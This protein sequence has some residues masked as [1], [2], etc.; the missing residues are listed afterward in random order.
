MKVEVMLESRLNLFYKACGATR[1][2][3]SSYPDLKAML[4]AEHSPIRLILF[5]VYLEDIPT[6]VSTHFVRH[7]IGVEHFVES[8]RDNSKGRNA[9]RANRETPVNHLMVC[10]AQSLIYMARKRLCHKADEIT[11]EI[12][13][14]I[15]KGVCEIMPEF[16]TVLVPDCLYRGK[17]YEMVP[18]SVGR[19]EIE[20]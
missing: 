1:A 17:C 10:N 5:S 20:C 6:Y 9:G 16:Y 8:N 15:K 7:K 2:K 18:C 12:M 13:Q 19:K 3:E 11:R 14:G 4:K